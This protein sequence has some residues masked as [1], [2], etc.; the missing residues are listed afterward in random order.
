MTVL[1]PGPIA[2]PPMRIVMLIGAQ[3][4]LRAGFVTASLV[5]VIV[6]LHEIVLL[7]DRLP[8]WIPLGV[9]GLL[10]IGVAIGYE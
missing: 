9:A 5:L 8:R 4:R 2:Y 7:W 1:D 10:V 3:L 6:A